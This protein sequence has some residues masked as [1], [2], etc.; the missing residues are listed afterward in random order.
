MKTLETLTIGAIFTRQAAGRQASKYSAHVHEQSRA[1]GTWALADERL[2]CIGATRHCSADIHKPAA[3][4]SRNLHVLLPSL[5]N[6][7][8]RLEE[9]GAVLGHKI[10]SSVLDAFAG[11]TH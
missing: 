2:P 7:Q 8:Q 4:S 11:M 10:G 1:T 6:L 5:A 9:A 3:G